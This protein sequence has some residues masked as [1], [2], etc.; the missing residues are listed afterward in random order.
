MYS[1]FTNNLQKELSVKF[2]EKMVASATNVVAVALPFTMI[3]AI[4]FGANKANDYFDTQE[5][6]EIPF[7]ETGSDEVPG[8]KLKEEILHF[9]RLPEGMRLEYVG[10]RRIIGGAEPS[11]KGIALAGV[12]TAFIDRYPDCDVES[13]SFDRGTVE[14]PDLAVFEIRA[15]EGGACVYGLRKFMEANAGLLYADQADVVDGGGTVAVSAAT[16][17][18]V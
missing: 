4:F 3:G 2:K 15:R 8:W 14:D 6:K 13:V 1:N 12:A 18:T 10:D 17:F 5:Q 11:D 16:R 9:G 7:E